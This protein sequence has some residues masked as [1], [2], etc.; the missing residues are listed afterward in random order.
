MYLFKDAK[1]AFPSQQRIAVMSGLHVKSVRRHLNA[2][3][4]KGWLRCQENK[5]RGKVGI[6]YEYFPTIPKRLISRRDTMSHRTD[7]R[8][9][10]VSNRG[11]NL[12]PSTGHPVPIDGTPCPPNQALNQD[13]NHANKQSEG[14]SGRNV[15]NDVFR[16]K[17]SIEWKEAAA[18]A[19]EIGFRNPNPG[20]RAKN[21]LRAARHHRDHPPPVDLDNVKK[22]RRKVSIVAGEMRLEVIR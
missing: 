16:G 20:E 19:M 1:S 21:Y 7:S 22:L 12:F 13:L 15:V 11:D 2:A 14:P 4:K 10:T 3:T 6:W 9:D 8:R 5:R 18:L 17:T